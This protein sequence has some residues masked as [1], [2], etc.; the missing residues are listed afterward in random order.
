MAFNGKVALITGGGSGMGQRAAQ[1]LAEQGA[2]VAILDVNEAGM[3]ET[4]GERTNI[5]AYPVDITDTDAVMAAVAAVE[6]ELGPIDRVCNA[7]AIM[8]FGKLM[9]QD[10]R[11]QIKLMDINYGG[12]VNVAAAALPGMLK[13]GSG[14][15]VSFSSM[16]GIIPGLL[17]GGYCSSKAAV[18]TYTEILYHENRDSGVRFVCVC[19][20]PVATPLWK[21]AHDTVVPELTKSG[22]TLQPE[23]VL[24]DI[25]ACLEAGKFLS[26]PGKQTR[27][28]YL[29]RR[30]F[31]GYIWNYS[32]KAEG[33]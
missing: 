33:F 11:V 27:M 18:S 3:A 23:D 17:M 13:R 30:L 25:E 10:P 15:F 28:G 9:E 2:A 12:L 22:E 20:P 1:L 29:M 26:F 14:D 6:S 21:Q 31:P 8:P 5:K 16:S 32:H 4:A 19:P 24:A 7:A